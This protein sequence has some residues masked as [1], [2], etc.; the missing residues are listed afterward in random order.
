MVPQRELLRNGRALIDHCTDLV[1]SVDQLLFRELV[2]QHLPVVGEVAPGGQPSDHVIPV[3]RRE[4]SQDEVLELIA[5]GKLHQN[6][7]RLHRVDR[8]IVFF[9]R[10]NPK[11]F[12]VVEHLGVGHM[13]AFV[14]IRLDGE[15]I[16]RVTQM[17]LQ[18]R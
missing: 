9:L 4:R 2:E 18:I 10:C 8:V 14:L 5:P 11:I 16:L 1:G 3:L 7:I 15:E 12:P 17:A 6:V 13:E